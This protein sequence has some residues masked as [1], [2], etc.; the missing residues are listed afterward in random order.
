VISQVIYNVL[1]RQVEIE[2]LR[3]AQKYGLATTV[4]NPLAGGLLA[5]PVVREGGAIPKGS[6]F[7]NNNQYQNRYWTERM[8][9]ATAALDEAA[10]AHDRTLVELAYAWLAS[11]PGVDSIL[12]GPG[13]VAH[14]DAALAAVA[15]PAPPELLA[16][17]DAIHADFTGTDASYAR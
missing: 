3:F 8:F 12:V 5:R 4:Y 9:D 16:R 14:L 1:V 7:D 13:S 11:R 15:R 17:V 6:G 2:Y 10:R